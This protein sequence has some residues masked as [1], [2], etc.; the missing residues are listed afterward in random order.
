MVVVD[1]QLP[2]NI[3]EVQKLTGCLALLNYFIA[4]KGDMCKSFFNSLKKGKFQ[5]TERCQ[6]MF[7]NLKAYLLDTQTLSKPVLS[8]KIFLYFATSEHAISIVL[9]REEGRAHL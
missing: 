3:K 6:P 8:E 7:N 2:R 9:I 1:M 5:W 4:R